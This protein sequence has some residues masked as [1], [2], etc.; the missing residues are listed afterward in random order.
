LTTISLLVKVY[1]PL[2]GKLLGYLKHQI[3]HSFADIDVTITKI[4]SD[5]RNHVEVSIIG[6][7][8]EFAINLLAKEYGR[9]ARSAD[10]VEGALLEGYLV[11]VGRVGFGIFVDV[12]LEKGAHLDPLIP[13]HTLRRHF[14]VKKPLKEISRIMGFTENLPLEVRLIAV[15]LVRRN[16]EAELSEQTLNRMNHWI[17]DDHE[18]LLVLGVSLPMIKKVL[19]ESGHLEDIYEFER[20]GTFEFALVCKRSTRASGI[21]AAIGPR[22]R[23]VPIHLF[24]PNEIK[25]WLDA[26]T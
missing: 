2:R 12:G 24:I 13:L 20:L 1:G 21:V 23:G 14:N 16:V 6:D 11:D 19:I 7:D 3:S 15:D 22:L 4:D 9:C 18:R 10:I 8:T 5:K 26:A 25:V 17:Q